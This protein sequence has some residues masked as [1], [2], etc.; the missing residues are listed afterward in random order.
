[1][2]DL[3]N[4]YYGSGT[5]HKGRTLAEMV[6]QDDY[7]FEHTHDFIQWMFPLNEL[8]RASLYAPLVDG[9]TLKAFHA[10]PLL[11]SNM[12]VSLV[13]FLK[14]LG[15]AF[16]GVNLRK[17][18][19]WESRKHEWFTEHSHNSLRI[20][21]ILKSMVLLGLKTDAVQLHLGLRTLCQ[22][23]SECAV[24][25]ESRAIWSEAIEGKRRK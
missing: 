8:S 17:T 11:K 15:L 18:S 19:E 9:N 16:D 23:E 21:R 1:M 2:N 22:T 14:F 13:R 10:D 3:L 7:W 20:T 4:F 5:D 25:S 12:R 6:T 24:T